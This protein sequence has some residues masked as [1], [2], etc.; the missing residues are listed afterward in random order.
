MDKYK[1][2]PIYTNYGLNED[3]EVCNVKFCTIR[4]YKRDKYGY[5]YITIRHHGNTL[6][7]RLGKFKYEC[8]NGLIVDDKVIDHIDNNPS[9]DSLDNL[10]LITQSE[11][12]RKKYTNGYCNNTKMKKVKAINM[13]DGSEQIYT[14]MNGAGRVLGIVEASVRRVCEGQQHTAIAHN[15]GNI[16]RYKFEYIK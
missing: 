7:L 9:N 13:D 2:H 8:A 12:I 1:I 3:G 11:N 4:K 10:Q 6:T 15:N 5:N 16:V 14:S